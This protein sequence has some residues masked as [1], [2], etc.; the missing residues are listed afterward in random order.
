MTYAGCIEDFGYT[1]TNGFWNNFHHSSASG[2]FDISRPKWIRSLERTLDTF[3]TLQA[4]WDS[5]GGLPINEGAIE[6]AKQFL[7]NTLFSTLDKPFITPTSN[8]GVQ[9]EWT[10]NGKD[11]EIAFLSLTE[12]HYFYS[13]STSERENELHSNFEEARIA[14]REF[15]D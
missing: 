5:Y 15:I 3:R 2:N 1:D 11:L 9:V 12:L 13:D 8:G 4:G 14:A 10:R 6:H 7:N